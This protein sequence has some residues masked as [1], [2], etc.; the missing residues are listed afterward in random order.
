LARVARA[1]ASDTAVWVATIS[2]VVSWWRARARIDTRA[3]VAGNRLRVTVRNQ[4]NRLVSGAVVR[5]AKPDAKRV[6]RT[7]TRLL[8]S[9]ARTLRLALPSLPARASRT[10]TVTFVR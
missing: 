5:V 8:P 6:A 7:D 4:S 3:R 1:V 10:F 2:D 9:D